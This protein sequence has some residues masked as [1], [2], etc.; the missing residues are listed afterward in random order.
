[1][2]A[3]LSDFMVKGQQYTFSFQPSGIVASV[4]RPSSDSVLSAL[5]FDPLLSQVSVAVQPASFWS[6]D[7]DQFNITFIY[8]GAGDDQVSDMVSSILDDLSNQ[9]TSFN[10]VSAYT[11]ATGA[12]ADVANTGG[13]DINSI[14]PST[15]GI[16][17][18]AIIVLLGVF[19]V[20]G[21]PSV[22]RSLSA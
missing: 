14:I 9:T 5:Q 10:F 2:D 21:G 15:S 18:I 17:A 19:V 1:M 22:A 11:G 8:A 3:Q 16:W 20:S 6:V 13:I 4:Y 7:N 12:P